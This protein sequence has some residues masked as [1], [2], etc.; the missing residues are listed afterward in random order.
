MTEEQKD[1]YG[2]LDRELTDL[3]AQWRAENPGAA[4]LPPD[5]TGG[6]SSRRPRWFAPAALVAAAVLVAVAIG[7]VLRPG[8]GNGPGPASHDQV[9]DRLDC[10]PSPD[11]AV[12]GTPVVPAG[13]V[14]VRLCGRS[15]DPSGFESAWPADTRTGA[16]AAHVAAAINALRPLDGSH[17]RPCFVSVPFELVLRYSDGRRV[18][19]SGTRCNGLT[20]GSRSWMGP[21]SISDLV[22]RLIDQQRDAIGPRPSPIPAQCPLKWQNLGATLGARPVSAGDDVAVTACQYRLGDRRV[23]RSTGSL[24]FQ[25]IL[26]EPTSVLADALTGTQTSCARLEDTLA[27]VQQ[28]LIVRDAYGDIHLVPADRCR[29]NTL[30]GRSQYPSAAL[31]TDLADLFAARSPS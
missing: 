28:V 23:N 1:P 25:S 6:R 7:V 15:A 29:T 12:S 17:S 13:A 27:R 8:D 31:V 26:T 9:V 22:L 19:T 14:A 11:R 10:A 20:V 18:T 5:I 16:D 21:A 30:A 24:D 4:D 2:D 3:G